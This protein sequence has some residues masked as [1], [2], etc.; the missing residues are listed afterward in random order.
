MCG[1]LVNLISIIFFSRSYSQLAFSSLLA[2]LLNVLVVWLTWSFCVYDVLFSVLPFHLSIL[3]HMLVIWLASFSCV[4]VL[5]SSCAVLSCHLS[6]RKGVREHRRTHACDMFLLRRCVS[7]AC[8]Q[9]ETCICLE[10]LVGKNTTYSPSL[11]RHLRV[12]LANGLARLPAR[13]IAFR[14][15]LVR[16]FPSD[17]T[18]VLTLFFFFHKRLS[19]SAAVHA[20]RNALAERLSLYPQSLCVSEPQCRTQEERSAPAQHTAP[21]HTG[22]T[23]HNCQPSQDGH[24]RVGLSLLQL[25]AR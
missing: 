9:C 10:P 15:R 23:D 19:S 4:C 13:K 21:R 25:S 24:P 12:N 14:V 18:P 6:T 3:L 20:Q 2:I 22:G 7:T 11:H 5:C 16:P 17:L 8:S 1:R